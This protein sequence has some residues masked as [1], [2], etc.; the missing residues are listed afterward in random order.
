MG[1]VVSWVWV[2]GADQRGGM[3]RWRSMWWVSRS[4]V[5]GFSVVVVCEIDNFFVCFFFLLVIMW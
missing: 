4:T 2:G 5:V 3:A 1:C